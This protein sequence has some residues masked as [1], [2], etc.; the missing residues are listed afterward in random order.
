MQAVQH[1]LPRVDAATQLK[2]QLYWEGVL[3]QLDTIKA[4]QLSAPERID[5][6]ATV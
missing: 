2:R 6:A 5:F 1:D 4:A 3:K